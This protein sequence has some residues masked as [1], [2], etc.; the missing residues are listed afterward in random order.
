MEWM[1][2]EMEKRDRY[3]KDK[4]IKRGIEE[5]EELNEVKEIWNRRKVGIEKKEDHEGKR[6]ELDEAKEIWNGRKVV[7]EKEKST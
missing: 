5:R 7:M 2:V 6:E 3:M 1:E 4:R